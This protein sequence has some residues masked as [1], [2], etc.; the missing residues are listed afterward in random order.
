MIIDYTLNAKENLYVKNGEELFEAR[1]LIDYKKALEIK[2]EYYIN[3]V[4]EIGIENVKSSALLEREYE[5]GKH[6]GKHCLYILGKQKLE[7]EKVVYFDDLWP[8]SYDAYKYQI[9]Y[10]LPIIAIENF[11]I[12][13]YSSSFDTKDYAKYINNSAS[14]IFNRIKNESNLLGNIYDYMNSYI[15]EEKALS[16]SVL[17]NEVLNYSPQNNNERDLRNKLFE[18]V[19]ITKLK[20]I[21]KKQIRESIISAKPWGFLTSED[22]KKLSDSKKEN[23]NK[24]LRFDD[25][26]EAKGT[27]LDFMIKNNFISI[28]QLEN[29]GV[30][31]SLNDDKKESSFA[32]K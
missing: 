2:K 8:D 21:N 3:N 16:V 18:C 24:V 28:E 5:Y 29:V 11:F 12:P 1:I 7:N 10:Y 9:G 6:I 19:E 31:M 26:D 32:R 25:V 17:F 30:K 14:K 27:Q 22:L 15:E 13:F 4:K 23:G 20:N